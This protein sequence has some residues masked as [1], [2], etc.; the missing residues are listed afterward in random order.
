MT[1]KELKSMNRSDL[2]EL[3]E[4]L[5]KDNDNLQSQINALSEKLN[6]RKHMIEEA[7]SVA[8]ASMQLNGVFSSAQ[9]AVA[10]YLEHI[11]RNA[12]RSAERQK[13]AKEQAEKIVSDA[14]A[15]AQR[16]LAETEEKVDEIVRNTKLE[17]QQYWDEVSRKTEKLISE[18]KGLCEF[19]GISS[20]SDV[21]YSK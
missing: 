12:A 15:E 16:L 11:A 13:A 4:G 14:Q 5:T 21:D 8:E 2:L 9:A 3:L 18:H 10:Q 17:A 7:D 19:L 1:E 20:M 6:E